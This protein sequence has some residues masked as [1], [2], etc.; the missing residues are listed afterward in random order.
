MWSTHAS[1]HSVIMVTWP[2]STANAHFSLHWAGHGP[3]APWPQ[4]NY[5]CFHTV[6]RVNWQR[7]CSWL[8]L[9]H[10]CQSSSNQRK[11]L[12]AHARAPSPAH[13]KP[14]HTQKYIYTKK[15]VRQTL[16]FSFW[17]WIF[18]SHFVM[19]PL[20]PIGVSVV[21]YKE[22]G[23]TSLFNLRALRLSL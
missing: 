23:A 11:V 17:I 16:F 14:K 10:A 13:R 2:V 15:Y 1:S 18:R 7:P 8:D 19:I 6:K 5:V 12:S 4:C 22:D 3:A 9:F 20:P 21:Q